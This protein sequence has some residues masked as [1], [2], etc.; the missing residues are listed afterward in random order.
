MSLFLGKIHYWLFNKILWLENIELNI[1]ELC[2]K[3]GFNLEEEKERIEKLYGKRVENKNLE[4][5]IDLKNIHGWLA[6]KIEVSEG[7]VHEWI[8][9]FIKN[10]KNGIEKLENLYKELGS[11]DGEKNKSLENSMEIYEG[12]NNYI[13][14]GMPCDRINEIIYSENDKII[15]K[16][17]Y[18]PST[19]DFKLRKFWIEGFIKKANPNYMYLE[20]ENGEYIIE[21]RGL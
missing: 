5:I 1:I 20:K 17:K 12:I 14:D 4:D 7:R 18:T 15:W 6:N 19:I 8:K 10:D 11:I 3:E 21:K 16:R 13:L 9:F 2:K